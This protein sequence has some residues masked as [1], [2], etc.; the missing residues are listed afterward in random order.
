MTYVIEFF[1]SL[2]A[3][4]VSISID[5][6]FCLY[7]IIICGQLRLI[8]K[9]IEQLNYLDERIYES[10]LRDCVK[11]HSDIIRHK[12]NL[13]LLYGPTAIWMFIST[14]VIVCTQVLQATH[15]RI[16]IK[17][18]KS[19]L[20]LHRLIFLIIFHVNYHRLPLLCKLFV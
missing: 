18:K 20:K 5:G 10:Q 14:S 2:S 16:S 6:L 17:K 13:E 8:T 9:K 12:K 3:C 7:L 15:V 4:S 19:K 1:G 11:R